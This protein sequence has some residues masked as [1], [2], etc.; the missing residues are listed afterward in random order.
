MNED[1]GKLEFDEAQNKKRDTLTNIQYATISMDESKSKLSHRD[2]NQNNDNNNDNMMD[3]EENE[4][5][6]NTVQIDIDL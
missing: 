1:P 2:I 5:A 4:M 6:E 3:T